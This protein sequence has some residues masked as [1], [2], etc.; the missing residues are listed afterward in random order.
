MQ[1]ICGKPGNYIE[2][3]GQVLCYECDRQD[4]EVNKETVK[5]LLEQIRFINKNRLPRFTVCE[6]ERL[7]AG[8]R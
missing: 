8:V 5:S 1:C 6:P 2:R 7:Y 4:H 3:V